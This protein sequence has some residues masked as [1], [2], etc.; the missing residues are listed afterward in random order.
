M[1]KNLLALMLSSVLVLASCNSSQSIPND[2]TPS[3]SSTPSATNVSQDK[4]KG[5]LSDKVISS[6]NKF[7]IKLFNN[8]L[9][10]EKD[11]NIFLSPFSVN[12]AL[13]MTY[14]G[15]DGTTK[16]AMEKT[17]ELN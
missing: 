7:G 12:T 3:P 13:A 5:E 1:K 2:K 17:L 15:S 9:K 4:E 8:I 10:K 11:K 16:E 6:A 14:N